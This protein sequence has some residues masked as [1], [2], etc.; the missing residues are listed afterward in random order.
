MLDH[1]FTPRVPSRNR[2]QGTD[3]EVRLEGAFN[4]RDLGGLSAGRASRTTRGLVYRADSLD[5]LTDSDKQILFGDLAI[6]TVIDLRTPEEAGGDGLS[7][8]RLFPTLTVHSLP[9]IPDGRIGVEPFPVGDAEAVAK[10]YL[11]YVV[12]RGPIVAGVV[13]AIATSAAEGVPALF[14][15]AAGRDRTG[16]VAAVLL[17]L[18]GVPDRVVVA[19][20]EESNRQAA[21]VSQRLT[22]NPLYRDDETAAATGTNLVD[23]AAIRKFLELFR[24]EFG[25]PRVWA[26]AHGLTAASLTTLTPTLTTPA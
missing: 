16:V 19:D 1:S 23:P 21:E 13:Q 15:C 18:L 6:G 14:H 12:D 10:L 5:S 8:A 11:E 4:I 24:A 20:Y 9:V 17:A 26:L 2:P 22:L 3:R 25:S 7:D